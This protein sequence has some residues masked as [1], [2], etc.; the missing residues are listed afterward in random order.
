MRRV[1]SAPADLAKMSNNRKCE[2]TL[3][4]K[5][6]INNILYK[7]IEYKNIEYKN[8]EYKNNIISKNNIVYKNNIINNN[9]L[10]W[11]L[12]K[13]EEKII[14]YNY[15]YNNLKFIKNSINNVINILSD[16]IDESNIFNLEQ[17]SIIYL[18]SIYFSEKILK[19]DKLCEI[20]NYIL[21]TF[22][23][24]SVML[25]IHQQFLNEKIE[26]KI[27]YIQEMTNN[28]HLLN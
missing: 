4:C 28:I 13:K 14:N 9:I 3:L 15:S 26:D 27:I 20:F 8:I 19:K 24:Y 23:R 22:I 16:A 11:N 17:Y 7:N 5:K 25:I 12:N 21:L 2:P 6:P 10:F 18:I 1:K